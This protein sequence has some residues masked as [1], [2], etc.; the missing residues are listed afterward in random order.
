MKRWQ[1]LAATAVFSCALG[2]AAG[3]MAATSTPE[4]QVQRLVRDWLEAE[5]RGDTKALQQI[6]ADDFIGVAYGSAALYKED[7]VPPED[8]G[9]RI[10]PSRLKEMTVRVYGDT[11]VAIGGVE[12]TATEESGEFR[13]FIVQQKRGPRW[14]MVA[15]QLTR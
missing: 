1:V 5:S 4:S 11:A 9:P 2:V 8:A 6:I 15:A 12:V 3:Q 13:F 7:I 14:A 10:T